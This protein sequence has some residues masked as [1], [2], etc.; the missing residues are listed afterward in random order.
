MTMNKKGSSNQGRLS[1]F[2]WF[3]SMEFSYIGIFFGLT[4]LL[5]YLLGTWLDNRYLSSPKG[6]YF[7]L[8]IA[9]LIN[10]YELYKVA[11]KHQKN[12]AREE[13]NAPPST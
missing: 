4:W 1:R 12:L 5:G 2:D 11:K 10:F 7:G 13:A 8:G 9:S 3:K 6:V